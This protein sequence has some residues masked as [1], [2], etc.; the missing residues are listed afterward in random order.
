MRAVFA[1]AGGAHGEFLPQ[2]T[3]CAVEPFKAIK[4]KRLE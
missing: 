3:E 2:I 1:S 4:L